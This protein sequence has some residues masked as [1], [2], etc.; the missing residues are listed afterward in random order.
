MKKRLIIIGVIVLALLIGGGIV[1]YYSY[2]NSHFVATDDAQISADMLAVTPQIAGGI[3]GWSAKVGDE[4]TKGQVLGTQEIN[5]MLGSMAATLTTPAAQKAA[6]DLLSAKAD[7]KSPIDG[8]VIQS[9]A[10]TSQLASTSTSLA[11]VANISGA[12]ITANIK[13]ANINDIQVGQKVDITIDAF[14]GKA[15]TGSVE[16]IGRATESIFSLL[17]SQNSTGNYT[18]V[19]QLIPVK[20]NIDGAGSL[21]LMPGMNTS[22]KIIIK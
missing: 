16:N 4:V 12:Y 1:Y 9:T 18:K 20:I 14:P 2:Q 11:I 17:P 5:T 15:F 22:V 10:I 3:T 21:N 13:E 7:I 19:T 8:V 6:S